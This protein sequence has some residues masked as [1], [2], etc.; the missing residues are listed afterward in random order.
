M[1][2]RLATLVG[3]GPVAP[4]TLTSYQKRLYTHDDTS[5]AD[6]EVTKIRKCRQKT[7]FLVWETVQL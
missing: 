5:T 6:P 1:K 7:Y 3:T 4:K 2:D